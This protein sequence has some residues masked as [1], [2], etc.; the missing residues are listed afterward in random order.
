MNKVFGIGWA[1]TG[2]TTL[3]ECF[4]ILGFNHQSQRLDLVKDVRQ[5]NLNRIVAL[6]KEKDTFEDWPWIILYQELDKAFPGSRFIL[7]TREP[8][9][10]IRSYQN[11]LSRQGE[12][13]EELDEIRR[14]LYGLP[15]PNVAEEQLIERYVKH[16]EAVM[17]YF[18]DRPASLLIVNWENGD[19]WEELCDFLDKD[20]PAVPFP[21]ANRSNYTKTYPGFIS[22]L[23]AKIYGQMLE[24]VTSLEG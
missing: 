18:Q 23:I 12:A 9:K 3:G 15:I 4:K 14:I 16:N 24:I 6:A 11:M 20:I 10:W 17:K 13:S 21:H 1:K 5:R 8:E 7:T 2:T 22:K 19:G